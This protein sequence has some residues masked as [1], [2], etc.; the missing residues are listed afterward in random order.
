MKCGRCLVDFTR[1]YTAN[2]YLIYIQG[3]EPN[4]DTEKADLKTSEIERVYFTGIN[5]DLSIGIKEAIILALPI[6][7][8]CDSGCKGLCPVCGMNR[9]IKKCKCKVK[10]GGL[11]TPIETKQRSKSKRRKK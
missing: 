8:L 11:F 1:E 2:L 9:N 4:S 6:A 3:K 10:K 5:L 7:C